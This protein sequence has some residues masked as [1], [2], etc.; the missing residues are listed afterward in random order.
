MIYVFDLDGTL[1]HTERGDYKRSRPIMSRIER[2]RDLAADGHTIVISTARGYVT[3]EDHEE[4]TRSQLH[5]WGVPFHILSVGAK[6]Y[7]DHYID[8]RATN[9]NDFFE[10]GE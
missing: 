9:A 2:V 8:D 6:P 4:L 10:D 1:C 3:E 5:H 7:G